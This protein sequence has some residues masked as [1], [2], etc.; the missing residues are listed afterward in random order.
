MIDLY[1]YGEGLDGMGKK[2]FSRLISI[3]FDNFVES[4]E[5]ILKSKHG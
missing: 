1:P 2:M 5:L 3:S 4:N